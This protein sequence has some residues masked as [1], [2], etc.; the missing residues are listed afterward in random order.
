MLNPYPEKTAPD[1]STGLVFDDDR[2]KYWQEG[3]EAG[4]SEGYEAGQS[5][6]WGRRF[7]EKELD[8]PN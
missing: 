8:K 2:H 7:E 1:E 4:H 5:W 6:S 3:Y